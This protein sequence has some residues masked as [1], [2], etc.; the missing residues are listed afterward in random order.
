MT[1]YFKE[2]RAF[3]QKCLEDDSCDYTR[4]LEYHLEHI[5]FFMHERLIHLIVTVLFSV[6]TVACIIIVA[7]TEKLIILPLAIGLLILLI[8][9]IKHYYF[10]E[11]QTQELYKDYEKIFEKVNIDCDFI[12]KKDI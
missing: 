9:Y 7:C 4:L 2:Y 8:P 3:I 10:L 1:K 6:L 5:K 11:N 12:S